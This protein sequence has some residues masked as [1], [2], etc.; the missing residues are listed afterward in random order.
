MTADVRS[1]RSNQFD[2]GR[3][4]TA[5]GKL[6]LRADGQKSSIRRSWPPTVATTTSLVQPRCRRQI[7]IL[8]R[9]GGRGQDTRPA[10]YATEMGNSSD[11]GSRCRRR[12]RRRRQRHV[13]A[14]T[15]NSRASRLTAERRRCACALAMMEI[16]PLSAISRSPVCRRHRPLHPP[17]PSRA[18]PFSVQISAFFLGENYSQTTT[19]AAAAGSYINDAS[20]IMKHVEQRTRLAA[21]FIRPSVRSLDAR[22]I[23]LYRADKQPEM[24]LEV[25]VRFDQSESSNCCFCGIR[26]FLCTFPL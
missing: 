18:H 14:K 16:D 12:R 7:M 9:G 11:R 21:G 6:C 17:A 20:A 5:G 3:A 15:G 8:F 1:T 26:N 10:H 2:D 25:A 22:C 4:A 24:T 23:S 13:T 19:A